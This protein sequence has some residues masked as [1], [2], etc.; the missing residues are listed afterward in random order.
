MDQIHRAG[1]QYDTV[2]HVELPTTADARE[3]RSDDAAPPTRQL[4]E[5]GNHARLPDGVTVPA[6]SQTTGAA[7]QDPRRNGEDRR[8]TQPQVHHVPQPDAFFFR[9]SPPFEPAQNR[10][11]VVGREPRPNETFGSV[12]LR[13]SRDEQDEANGEEQTPTA[14]STVARRRSRSPNQEPYMDARPKQRSPNPCYEKRDRRPRSQTVDRISKVEPQKGHTSSDDDVSVET[15]SWRLQP[16]DLKPETVQPSNDDVQRGIHG[17]SQ[18]LRGLFFEATDESHPTATE[19]TKTS[20]VASSPLVELKTTIVSPLS[21][22]RSAHADPLEN[23]KQECSK[24]VLKCPSAARSEK[25]DT[26]CSKKV[27]IGPVTEIDDQSEIKDGGSGGGSG[28]VVKYGSRRYPT[29]QKIIDEPWWFYVDAGVGAVPYCRSVGRVTSENTS[30]SGGLFSQQES[31]LSVG[32]ELDN[33]RTLGIVLN[34]DDG[35]GGGGLS[36]RNGWNVRPEITFDAIDLGEADRCGVCA[37]TG[38][39]WT[40]DVRSAVDA[41][42]YSFDRPFTSF[43]D[44]PP[45]IPPLPATD[46]DD[47]GRYVD[48]VVSSVSSAEARRPSTPAAVGLRSVDHR[49]SFDLPGGYAASDPRA[50]IDESPATM[51]TTSVIVVLSG[52]SSAETATSYVCADGATTFAVATRRQPAST[53]EWPDGVD[54]RWSYAS[55]VKR[56]PPSSSSSSSL[57]GRRT[58][59]ENSPQAVERAEV[60]EDG[61]QSADASS[62]GSVDVSVDRQSTETTTTTNK[63][64]SA[65][66]VDSFDEHRLKSATYV[67]WSS[68]NRITEASPVA[69]NYDRFP[70]A[71]STSHNS[72]LS[73]AL[74][75]SQAISGAEASGGA[76]PN[77]ARNDHLSPKI[78]NQISSFTSSAANLVRI[79]ASPAGK[80][81]SNRAE[82]T[83][84]VPSDVPP[85]DQVPPSVLPLPTSQNSAN[86]G[87]VLKQKF[88]TSLL[89]YVVTG[90]ALTAEMLCL[91]CVAAASPTAADCVRETGETSRRPADEAR[92]NNVPKEVAEKAFLSKFFRPAAVIGDRAKMDSYDGTQTALDEIKKRKLL[93][94]ASVYKAVENLIRTSGPTTSQEQAAGATGCAPPTTA[95]AAAA[96]TTSPI[97]R[98]T[99]MKNVKIK[100]TRARRV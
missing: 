55:V 29:S 75:S 1:G 23:L 30:Y 49:E 91:G 53:S 65:S 20:E 100:E 6:S 56:P 9:T 33:A 26:S 68:Y 84:R 27:T 40:P 10:I 67:G 89:N 31:S 93:C 62:T 13:S 45:I 3:Q 61:S 80:E 58:V 25:S 35:G 85:A 78:C 21:A 73:V 12:P 2:E 54:S 24:P 98:R 57:V 7:Y 15:S 17:S 83:D 42:G 71:P 60:V 50:P 43:S 39:G 96:T 77:A 22:R 5:V 11:G 79:N 94:M 36:K 70:G 41:V 66:V 63:N 74:Q 38:T 95:T 59:G 8:A 76:P 51:T 81:M 99:A 4:F 44:V 37:T 48:F 34:D 69:E 92:S 88:T 52:G 16:V 47:V 19:S 46:F 97:L 28:G 32:P 82:P 87:R 86:A 72:V 64:N 90:E 14:S 18:S